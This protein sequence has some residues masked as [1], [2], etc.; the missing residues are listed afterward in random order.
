MEWEYKGITIKIDEDTG[1]FFFRYDK[2][3]LVESLSEAKRIIDEKFSKYYTFTQYD[4]N[5]L[6]GK[7]NK[8]EQELVKS[9][10]HELHYHI[11]NPYCELGICQEEWN[12]GW[13][14]NK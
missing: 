6:L 2:E 13:D 11:N 8:R 1:K 4:M 3:Y 14:F 7:L 9:L 10:Y 12:W 5:K